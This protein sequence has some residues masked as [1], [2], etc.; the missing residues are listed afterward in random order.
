MYLNEKCLGDAIREFAGECGIE[1]ADDKS[2]VIDH[3]NYDVTDN[4]Q[5]KE[6]KLFIFK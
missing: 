2:S 6:K 5:V 1:F 3:F 4:G